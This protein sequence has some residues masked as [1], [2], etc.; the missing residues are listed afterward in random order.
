MTEIRTDLEKQKEGPFHNGSHGPDSLAALH[1]L[2]FFVS[3]NNY[4]AGPTLISF[5]WR[6]LKVAVA[7]GPHS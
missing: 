2:A 5:Y 4:E 1:F 3:Q 6:S 7:M